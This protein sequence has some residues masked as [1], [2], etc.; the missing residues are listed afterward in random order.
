MKP[1]VFIS[2]S[3]KDEARK[4][5]VLDHLAPRV[6]ADLSTWNDRQ[7]APGGEWFE[8]IDRCEDRDEPYR[9]GSGEPGHGSEVAG[10]SEG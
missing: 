6:A 9:A 5:R 1:S 10:G 3:H 7:I 8:E 4:D 2:H